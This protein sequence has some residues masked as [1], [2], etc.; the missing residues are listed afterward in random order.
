MKPRYSLH[1]MFF[2]GLL[3]GLPLAA[4]GEP[5]GCSTS[6]FELPPPPV[7]KHAPFP[8]D[9]LPPYL[10]GLSLTE[11][12]RVKI[13]DILKTPGDELRAK[14]EASGK[15]H[16]ELRQLAFTTDYSEDKAKALVEANA[17]TM[18]ELAILHA[19]MDH[20]IYETLTP[21]QQRQVQANLAD[22]RARFPKR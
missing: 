11:A 7:G 18:A 10:D 9:R 15:P 19:R 3:L 16:E 17:S 4:T 2:C 8:A 21:G 22:F 5:G 1:S 14:A 20:A 13:T 12:Q 6:M